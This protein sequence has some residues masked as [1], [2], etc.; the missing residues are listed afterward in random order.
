MICKIC[1][2]NIENEDANFCEY[3]GTSLRE[4]YSGGPQLAEVS[5]SENE[6]QTAK[7]ENKGKKD[8]SFGMWLGMMVL[9]FIPLIGFPVFVVLLFVWAFGAESSQTMKNW[10]RATLIV[11]VILLIVMGFFMGDILEQ[12]AGGTNIND[13]INSYY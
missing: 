12:M 13:I 3:C 10:A 5:F 4:S 1:G 8:V 11:G 9:P 7:Q 2:R 6:K